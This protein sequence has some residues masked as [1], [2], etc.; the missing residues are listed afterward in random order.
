MEA[1]NEG[2]ESPESNELSATPRVIDKIIMVSNVDYNATGQVVKIEYG[3]GITTENT[4]DPLTL[5]L[6]RRYTYDGT[7]KAIQDFEYEYDGVGNIMEI[8]DNV[9][10]GTQ[11]FRYDA[12]NRLVYARGAYGVKEY[13]YDEIGNIIEKDGLRYTYGEGNAG[14]HAVTSLSDG[15][16]FTYDGNG[17]MATMQ[18]SDELTEYLYDEENRLREVKKSGEKISTYE[19]DGDGGRTRKIVYGRDVSETDYVGS[20]YEERDNKGISYVF[21]GGSRVA[22][23]VDGVTMFYHQDHLGGTNVLTDV[24]GEV[25]ELIEYKPYGSFNRH[26]KYGEE[27]VVAWFYFT[28]KKLDDETGLYYY[29]ARYYDPLIG[30]FIQADTVVPGYTNPQALN[31]YSYCGNNPVNFTD[32]DGHGF[33][34]KVGNFFKKVGN[35]FSNIGN[36]LFTVSSG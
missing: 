2:G 30:R 18:K 4:Y 9:H 16:D 36:W 5:R 20:L 12:M 6:K 10:I 14:P 19:Y 28:G 29:G 23:L 32:P 26:E 22:S 13:E 33:W 27:E 24:E 1:C 8:I 21:L 31:R 7:G 17:N 15:T 25:K 34:K 35:F 3:N 11:S